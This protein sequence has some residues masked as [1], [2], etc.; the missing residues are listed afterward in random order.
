MNLKKMTATALTAFL[1]AA[2]AMA[3]DHKDKSAEYHHNDKEVRYSFNVEPGE[4]MIFRDPVS[5]TGEVIET[6][7]SHR[8]V[9]AANDMVIRVPNEALVWNGDTQTFA[10]STE[11]GDEVVIHLR[12]E[13]PYRIIRQMTY[14]PD[15]LAVG[16]YDGVFF[17]SSDF[18]RDLAL[19][20]LDND[21]Y[22]R[23]SDD[24][25]ERRYDVDLA[26][27]KDSDNEDLDD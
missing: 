19:D 20:R 23:M 10:Q 15:M 21:I 27:V 2:P 12:Q 6:S 11:I 26:S 25:T 14:E 4:V 1:F 8:T 3:D 13:E 17:V 7:Q 9:R 18:I 22:A 5:F 24:A 16:G